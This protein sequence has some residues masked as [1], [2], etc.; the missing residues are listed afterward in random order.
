VEH[1]SDPTAK[2]RK[3]KIAQILWLAAI[4]IHLLAFHCYELRACLELVS[5]AAAS[6][7]LDWRGDTRKTTSTGSSP[8]IHRAGQDAVV[9]SGMGWIVQK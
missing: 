1:V 8:H 5:M 6:V 3:M 2:N 7:G 4:Y 9:G